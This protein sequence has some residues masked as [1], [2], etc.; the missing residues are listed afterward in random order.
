MIL[1]VDLFMAAREEV[2]VTQR[3]S[4]HGRFVSYTVDGDVD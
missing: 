3:V 1:L 2:R 4:A